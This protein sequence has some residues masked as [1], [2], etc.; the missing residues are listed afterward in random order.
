[1][2]TINRVPFTNLMGSARYVDTV[3]EDESDKNI[4]TILNDWLDAN[5][6]PLK[7]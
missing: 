2:S 7:P 1:M 5:F 4:T 3:Y 6:S